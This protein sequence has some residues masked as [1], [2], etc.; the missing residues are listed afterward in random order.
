MIDDKYKKYVSRKSLEKLAK[1]LKS[2]INEL[3]E[4]FV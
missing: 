2:D 3:I 1:M 4:D